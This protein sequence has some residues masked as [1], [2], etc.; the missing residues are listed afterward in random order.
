MPKLD[1]HTSNTVDEKVYIFESI[2]GIKAG[3]GGNL[4]KKENGF[5]W[6]ST[7]AARGVELPNEGCGVRMYADCHWQR[8]TNL[9]QSSNSYR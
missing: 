5:R 3:I 1:R 4:G 9:N 6:P 8:K 2:Y 7:N